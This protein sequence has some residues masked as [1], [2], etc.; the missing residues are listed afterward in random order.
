MQDGKTYTFHIAAYSPETMPMAV[1]AEYM[2]EFAA[3]LG[4]EHRV[5]FERLDPGST[6]IVS[7]AEPEDVPKVDQ[8]LM[9]V[10][11]GT[12]PQE[13]L[14]VFHA[15]DAKLA[16]DNAT[17]RILAEEGDGQTEIVVFPGCSRPKPR[18]FGP[19]NQDGTLD[20]V[21]SALSGPTTRFPC[22]CRAARRST[23][24]WSP[25]LRLGA[26]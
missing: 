3:L 6:N 20:G 13:L 14:K 7:R 26:S 23:P 4:K 21:V 5:H 19:I 1:L 16:N 12:A 18:I 8:R 22:S 11:D 2:A 9:S 24:T 10:R 25:I 15:L 17:G